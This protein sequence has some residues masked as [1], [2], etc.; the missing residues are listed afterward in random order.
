MKK[1]QEKEL[2]D[3]IKENIKRLNHE[4]NEEKICVGCGNH[5]IYKDMFNNWENPCTYY[6]DLSESE[7]LEK[8]EELGFEDPLKQDMIDWYKEFH[9]EME[10]FIKSEDEP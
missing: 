10:D 6:D 4:K 9:S 8:I 3:V 2:T 5:P 1:S 7:L